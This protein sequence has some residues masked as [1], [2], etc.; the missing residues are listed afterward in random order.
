LQISVTEKRAQIRFVSCCEAKSK[1][2]YYAQQNK[3]KQQQAKS[4]WFGTTK[5]STK[6]V[7]DKVN[8]GFYHLHLTW[9]DKYTWH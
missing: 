9:K 5:S 2:N 1:R 6:L 3:K 4:R 8:Q 7:L